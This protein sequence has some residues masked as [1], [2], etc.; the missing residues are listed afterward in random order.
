MSIVNWIFDSPARLRKVAVGT[1]IIICVLMVTLTIGRMP[2]PPVASGPLPASSATPE[3]TSS[4][5]LPVDP[6]TAEG[7]PLPEYGSSAPIALEAVNAFLLADHAGFARLAQ[8]EAVEAINEAPDPK[9][10]QQIIGVP[11]TV[12]GGPTRQ[13]IDV[14]TTDGV[15]RLDMIIVDG[16]WKVLD[17]RY[18]Q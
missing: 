7:S 15:L 6:G 9:P 4:E 5:L 16:A 2:S 12:A 3:P 1:A 10:G 8:Q 18:Q 14:R 17:M 11:T 13:T